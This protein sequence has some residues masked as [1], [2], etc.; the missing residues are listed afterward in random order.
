MISP[1]YDCNDV[2]QKQ[3]NNGSLNQNNG[4]FDYF[5]T[6]AEVLQEDIWAPKLLIICLDDVLRT[7]ID[8]IKMV[9]LWKMK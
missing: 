6:D 4:D 5:D 2:L 1:N 7:S 8:L 3:I 9:S